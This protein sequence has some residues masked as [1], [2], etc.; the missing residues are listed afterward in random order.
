[1]G[2]RQRLIDKAQL[3]PTWWIS[4]VLG[5]NLWSKQREIATSVAVN[6]R[7]AVPACFSA[8][9]TWLAG[10]LALW[11]LYC[12]T[13]SKVIT[14][15]DD[16]TEIQT[17]KRGWQLFK[18]LLPEDKVAIYTGGKISYQIP[19]AYYCPDY[20]GIML[21]YC[22]HD[23]DFMVT[24]NHRCI[25]G[26]RGRD[27][28]L[29][30]LEAADLYGND[31]FLIPVKIGS[32]GY[33]GHRLRKKGW[34][35]VNYTGKVYCVRVNGGM[36]LV[37]R[38]GKECWSGNSA[39]TARQVKNL[40]WSELRTAHRQAL[41]PLGGNPLTLQLDLASDHYAV[42][43]STKDYDIDKFTGY[44]APYVLVLFDQAGGL[45]KMFW[46]AG[47]G[48]MTGGF[49]RWLAVGN[50]AIAECEFAAICE[51]NRKTKYGDWNVIKIKASETPNV[52]A[53]RNIY[54][55][56]LPYDWVTKK[57][58]AWGV[59]DPLYRIF[60]D[61]EFVASVEKVVVSAAHVA[62]AFYLVG[63]YED[64]DLIEIGLDVAAGGIDMTVWIARRGSK[65]LEIQKV[66]GNDPMEVTGATVIFRKYLEKKYGV[67]VSHIKLDA[68][69]IGAGIYSRLLELEELVI[70]VINSEAAADPFQ[71]A[72]IRA[73]MAWALRARF[74]IGGVGLAGVI[75]TDPECLDMLRLDC[76]T[77]RYKISSTGR[78][79]LW[80]KELLRKLLKRSPDFWDALVMAFESPGGGAPVM[81]F[82][83]T[84]TTIL[85]Q[86]VA[87]QEISPLFNTEVSID[88]LEDDF[89]E[90]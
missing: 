32:G 88:D 38:N 42:G 52:Q 79:Q 66:T 41:I 49:V 70:P 4:T 55:A 27:Y 36:V 72:N 13:P 2:W 50:T 51:S 81:S 65:V 12:F 1:M 58:I 77:I 84:G 73:E 39:P 23:V 78:I 5:G 45:P 83:N 24:P 20:R 85:Q 90:F 44:H 18:D 35:K 64:K 47:E 71:F 75:A 26:G 19:L 9:K 14:C 8:G 46:E 53:G 60:A 22:S 61:A 37:R 33:H 31:Q 76:I 15:Y 11:F 87:T 10:R 48:L 30:S 82:I 86:D 43:F 56:L 6:E 57:Q 80:D 59:D 21:K 17:E 89:I 74:A 7:T 3:N 40:L 68:I 34:S 62:N 67:K 25:V 16:K 63:T 29:Q 69:G 54:P 28:S